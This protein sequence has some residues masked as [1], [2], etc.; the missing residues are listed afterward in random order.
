MFI[1]YI[2]TLFILLVIFTKNMSRNQRTPERSGVS[3]QI[4]SNAST[5]NVIWDDTYSRLPVSEILPERQQRTIARRQQIDQIVADRTRAA[6]LHLQSMQRAID[7]R[8]IRLG[9]PP[10]QQELLAVETAKNNLERLINQ[11][12][13]EVADE[14]VQSNVMNIQRGSEIN[15]SY[16]STGI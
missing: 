6:K 2:K 7:A 8:V 1:P 3:S 15:Q 14:L 9:I 13:L 5:P 16:R 11:T 10:T 12:R 4:S